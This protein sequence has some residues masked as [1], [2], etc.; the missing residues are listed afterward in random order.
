MRRWRWTFVLLAFTN[1]VNGGEPVSLARYAP[2][3]AESFS[4]AGSFIESV[5]CRIWNGSY[6][7]T[8]V[9]VASGGGKS[10]ILTC[11][12]L[13]INDNTGQREVNGVLIDIGGGRRPGRF[14][15]MSRG[16]VDLAAVEMDEEWPVVAPVADDDPRQSEPL[17]VGGFGSSNQGYRRFLTRH[18]YTDEHGWV[19]GPGQV[20]PGDSGSPVVSPQAR[21]VGII[22]GNLKYEPLW[23]ATSCGPIRGFFSKLTHPLARKGC[24]SCVPSPEP[25]E[26]SE[27]VQRRPQ[28]TPNNPP[29]WK[30]VPPPV[31]IAGPAGKPG[32]RGP[33]GPQGPPGDATQVTVLR[34]EI[35]ALKAELTAIR[36]LPLTVQVID[37]GG[38]V[39][40]TTTAT[41]GGE[42]LR[43]Q[44]IPVR[45]GGK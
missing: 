5:T 44:L 1:L 26:P 15:A 18:S 34:A 27:P 12:H 8:G 22:K 33:P 35:A 17:Q 7:G 31:P 36:K 11:K 2:V 20:R 16:S 38:K 32:E 9:V 39:K 40:Q 30:P 4:P 28:P 24:P 23:I 21:V 10:L 45:G 19:H 43:L 29:D 6:G 37:G 13:F 41:L 42:P 14:I 3:S 25:I